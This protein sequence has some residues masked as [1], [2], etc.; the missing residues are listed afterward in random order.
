MDCEPWRMIDVSQHLGLV[1]RVV[2][3]L[4]VRQPIQ[5][6]DEY[7]DGL[8]ALVIA[9]KH[10]DSAKGKFSSYATRAI[11][12]QIVRGRNERSG[13]GT[14]SPRQHPIVFEQMEFPQDVLGTDDVTGNLV[15]REAIALVRRILQRKCMDTYRDLIRRAFWD[16]QGAKEIAVDLQTTHQTVYNR[17]NRAYK[18]LAPLLDR[19]R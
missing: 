9:A 4:G 18:L 5:D 13:R 15:R 7:S 8:Y 1:R 2:L 6:S 14:G 17:I 11:I 16:G 12:N 3:Q 19:V 10:Y